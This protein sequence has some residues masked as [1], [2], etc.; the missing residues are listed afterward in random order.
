MIDR[1]V[2][3]RRQR[4]RWHAALQTEVEISLRLMDFKL[5]QCRR[6][7]YNLQSLCMS[8][9]RIWQHIDVGNQFYSANC[10]QHFAVSCGCHTSSLF[11]SVIMLQQQVYH[12]HLQISCPAFLFSVPS[13]CRSH[14]LNIPRLFLLADLITATYL[15]ES[16]LQGFLN[17]LLR[18]GTI[19]IWTIFA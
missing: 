1:L 4:L 10:M 9:C 17:V 18:F 2:W 15:S 3:H 14:R 19:N 13:V 12:K 16:V 11:R 5:S 6:V 7:D 8:N